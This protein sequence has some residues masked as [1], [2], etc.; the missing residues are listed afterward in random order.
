M[1]T[2]LLMGLLAFG[3]LGAATT[4]AYL[5]VQRTEERRQSNVRRS[6]LAADAPDSTPPGV[7]PVDT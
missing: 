7:E 4:F 2:E 6:T 3:T 5:R 1:T